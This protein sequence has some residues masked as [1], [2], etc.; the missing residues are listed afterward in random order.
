MPPHTTRK[1][2]A[3]WSSG[4]GQT[5]QSAPE[6]SRDDDRRLTGGVN[7]DRARDGFRSGGCILRGARAPHQGL[8]D[9]RGGAFARQGRYLLR[10]AGCGRWL[11]S[12]VAQGE[13]LSQTNAKN[14]TKSK[15]GPG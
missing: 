13:R 7:F 12:A 1:I 11:Q 8:A 9:D 10:R 6:G 3:I 2:F 4:N 5:G 14:K 15:L